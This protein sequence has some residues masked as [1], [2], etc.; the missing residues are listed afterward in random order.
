[1]TKVIITPET[2][3]SPATAFRA[4]AGRRESVAQTPGAALDALTKQLDYAEGGT[5]IVVQN[6]R[7]DAFFSIGQQKRLGELM[8]KWR[9]ART[10]GGELGAVEQTELETLVDLELDGSGARA[11]AMAKELFS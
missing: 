1:M 10:N 7:P 2:P 9:T 5:L 4:S 8:E 11:E 6:M 3:G